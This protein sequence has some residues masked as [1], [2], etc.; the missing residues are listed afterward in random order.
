MVSVTNILYV[1]HSH[2]N[3]IVVIRK[4]V[5]L[6]NPTALFQACQARQHYLTIPI[7]HGVGKSLRGNPSQHALQLKRPLPLVAH[8]RHRSDFMQS[9][10]DCLFAIRPDGVLHE[11]GPDS[12][13]E[14][15]YSKAVHVV[16]HVV[17]FFRYHALP[18]WVTVKILIP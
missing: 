1:L 6:S 4:S 16:V 2:D 11:G 17:H 12:N 3:A 8:L 5:R 18:S 10:Q 7:A 14:Q 9:G 13:L 15:A